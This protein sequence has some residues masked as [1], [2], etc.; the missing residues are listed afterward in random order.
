MATSGVYTFSVSRD[1]IIREA[2]LNIRKLDEL[3]TPTPQETQDCA[4]KLNMLVKQWQSNT[5][6]AP[7]LKTWTRRH[8]HL[9]LSSST[10]KYSLGPGATGWT[11]EYVETTASAAAASGQAVLIVTSA[12]G[13]A[14]GSYLGVQLTSGAL[15][16]GTVLSVA[17]TTVT[18]TSNLSGAVSANAVVYS[19]VTTAQQP[20]AI[21]TAFLRNSFGSDSSLHIMR[22]IQ[23][24]D[25]L[26]TKNDSSFVADPTAIYYE[27]QLGSGHLYTDVAAAD[28]LTKHI[29]MSYLEA[30]Q[31]FV[32]PADTPEYP[33]EWYLALSWGLAKQIA[34]MYGANWTQ[35]MQSNHDVAL[36]IA[37]QKE[38]ET[39]VMYFQPGEY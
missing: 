14:A 27:F 15:A 30:V 8:G 34:P 12:A 6:F 38:P 20:V 22:S 5:D 18:L 1:D 2:L 16:W 13:I 33:Q 35:L 32:N 29:G 10:G 3:E 39:V 11:N 17:S 19:Y 25:A 23:E 7:G 24:Y 21:E 4:R 28:D 26:P 37:Q 36:G 9:F 31:D